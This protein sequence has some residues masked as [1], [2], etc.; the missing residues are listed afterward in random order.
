MT[1]LRRRETLMVAAALVLLSAL[2][3]TLY[4]AVR[5]GGWAFSA[6]GQLARDFQYTGGCPVSLKFDWG[7]ISTDPSVITYRTTRNDGA[8]APARSIKHPGGGRSMPIIENWRLGANTPQFANYRGWLQ[9]N[10][11]SPNGATNRIAFTLHCR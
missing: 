5:I 2:A 11:E 9:I 1:L 7:V 10:V 6:N 4:G 8:S 3:V